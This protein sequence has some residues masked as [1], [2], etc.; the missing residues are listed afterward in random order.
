[1]EWEENGNVGSCSYFHFLKV[2]GFDI[3]SSVHVQ[4]HCLVSLNRGPCAVHLRLGSDGGG[5][6]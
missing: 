2:G 1:M 6:G 3:S 5:G 4:L